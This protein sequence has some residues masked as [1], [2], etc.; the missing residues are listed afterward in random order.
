MERIQVSNLTPPAPLSLRRVIQTWWPLAASWLLM[1]AEQ[2]A[3]QAIITRLPHLDVNLAAWG[4]VFSLSLIVEAPII[5]LLAASTA[6]SKDWRSYLWLRRFMMWA[7]AILTAVHVLVAFTPLYYVVM[8]AWLGQQADVTAV[9][10]AAR[11]GLMLMTPWTWSIAYR[12][13][14]QGVLIRCGHSR[15]VGIGTLVRLGTEV[16]MLVAGYLVGTIPGT[17]VAGAAIAV[18]VMSE[19]LYTGLR[20]RPVLRDQVRAAPPADQPLA[21]RSFLAF[22]VPLS[23]TSLL[24]L[25]INPLV[26]FALSRMP[27]PL[28]SLDIW[29][30]ISG[31]AFVLRS[32]GVAYNEVVVALAD[33][34]QA[35]R[36]LRRFAAGLTVTVTLLTV[37]IAATRLSSFWFATAMGLTPALSTLAQQAFWLVLPLPGLNVLQ[38]WYQGSIVHHGRTRG[39]TEAMVLFLV[40][41]S[42]TMV[43]G[44][45][46]GQLPGLYV[47]LIGLA[48]GFTL[49]TGWLWLRSRPALHG[50]EAALETHGGSG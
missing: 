39:I 45:L 48:V 46:W 49:Q 7:G 31:L 21:L 8:R 28:E 15:A 19:A 9:I 43:A 13:L 40:S 23:L 44:V 1:S 26:T 41:S 32:A 3:A 38:S 34:V 18:G 14:H 22:Y 25:L 5:M 12:R 33:R 2:P 42:G 35:V 4:V 29:P 24:Y 36:A 27:D 47:G 50:A 17:A 30:V 37:L 11:P 10:E 20:V 16:T 6:L